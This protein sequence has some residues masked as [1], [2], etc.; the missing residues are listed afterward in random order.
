MPKVTCMTDK[1]I[2]RVQNEDSLLCLENRGVFMVADGVGGHKAGKQAS[3]M[4]VDFVEDFVK[5]HPISPVMAIHEVQKYM[6]DCF[7][8]VNQAIYE[9]A[10]TNSEYAGM[11]TTAILLWLEQNQAYVAN[12]GDSR[13]YL[14][15][16]GEL[17]RLTEDHSYVNEL[18]KTGQITEEEALLHPKRNMITR[19]LGSE[20]KVEPDVYQFAVNSGDRILLC[21]DGLYN[22]VNEDEI[23]EQMRAGNGMTDLALRLVDKANENGGRDN[24]TVIC[25]TI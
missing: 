13:A 16:N 20:A 23:K 5:A 18:I 4:A 21:T 14:L 8:S 3:S 15:H 6:N 7:S 9:H 19:A 25:V 22:E 12:V 2:N 10:K 1:G 17:T 11:A 24:I